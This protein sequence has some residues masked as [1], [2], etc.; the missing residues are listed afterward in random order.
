[1]TKAM[2]WTNSRDASPADFLS[3]LERGC[4]F[5]EGLGAGSCDVDDSHNPQ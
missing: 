5:T 1:M 3:S 4:S 2:T